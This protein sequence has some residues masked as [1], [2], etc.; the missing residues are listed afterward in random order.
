MLYPLS[1]EGGGCAVV[2]AIC[3]NTPHVWCW[4]G[5]RGHAQRPAGWFAARP[6]CVR[7]AP[8]WRACLSRASVA[9]RPYE[10]KAS[11]R[12]GTS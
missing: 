2:C 10:A 9:L 11:G 1:Y 3:E 8:C 4:E 5:S 12:F 7:S 6:P